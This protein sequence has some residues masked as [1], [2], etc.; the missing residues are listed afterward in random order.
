MG[1]IHG[2]FSE[3]RLNESEDKISRIFIEEILLMDEVG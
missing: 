1:L 2:R 3:K